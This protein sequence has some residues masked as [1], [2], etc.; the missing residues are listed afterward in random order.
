[1][2]LMF[3]LAP[4]CRHAIVNSYRFKFNT[5]VSERDVSAWKIMGDVDSQ[6]PWLNA[7]NNNLI[8]K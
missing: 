3:K 8:S 6:L 7:L 1:M 2:L 4:F 5:K